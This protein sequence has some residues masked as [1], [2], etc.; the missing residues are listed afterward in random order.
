MFRWFEMLIQNDTMHSNCNTIIH[1]F[2]WIKYKNPYSILIKL[3]I[4]NLIIKQNNENH[5]KLLYIPYY[6]QMFQYILHQ[7][8]VLSPMHLILI[9]AFHLLPVIKLFFTCLFIL[10]PLFEA[11]VQVNITENLILLVKEQQEPFYCQCK[12]YL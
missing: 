3:L 12:A 6:T 9:Q 8:Y 1:I 2:I 7:Y 11:T 5:Y 4:I 10:L